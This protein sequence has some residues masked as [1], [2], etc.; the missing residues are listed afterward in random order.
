MAKANVEIKQDEIGFQGGVPIRL[1]R[2]ME[3]KRLLKTHLTQDVDQ[4][5]KWAKR[6]Q[7]GRIEK[8]AVWDKQYRGIKPEKSDPFVG[9]SNVAIPRTRIDVDTVA[10]R[11]FDVIYGQAKMIMV[12]A[13]DE[14]FIPLA[15]Q[16]EDAIEWWQ[17]EVVHL[18]DKLF[19]PMYQALKSG[20]GAVKL[21]FERKKQTQVRYATP[22]EVADENIKTFKVKGNQYATKE[23]RTIFNGPNVYGLAREDLVV[24]SEAVDIDNAKLVGFKFPL[25]EADIKVGVKSGYYYKDVADKMKIPDEVDDTKKA[26]VESQDKE[27]RSHE[28]ED[29]WPYELWLKYDV[30]EDGEPDDIVVIYHEETQTILRA[31]Y[32]PYFS[33]FRPIEK[34]VTYPSEYSFEGVGICERLQGL[35][36]AIDTVFNMRFDRLKQINL[37][38]TIVKSDAG[39]NDF[40]LEPGKTW[41]TD[42]DV[43]AAIR[44]IQF[45]PS[46]PDTERMEIALNN[47]SD[48]SV[49]IGPANLGQPMSERPVA[50]ETFMLIQELNKG[51]KFV[52]DN[53]RD[54]IAKII[55]KALE[56]AAQYSPSWDYYIES[57]GRYEKKTFNFPVE[58]LRDG[59]KVQLTASSEV[60]NQEVRREIG[61]TIWQ[62]LAE[63]MTR[64]AGMAQIIVS[65]GVPADFKMVLLEAN[66]IGV[67]LMKQIIKDFGLI[68]EEKVV[69][70]LAK[71]LDVQKALAMPEQMPPQP[72]QPPQGGGQPQGGQPQGAM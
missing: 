4:K 40:E 50:R 16:L 63:Y 7:E 44:E 41:F 10:V 48:Q 34:L 23:I 58:Y 45:H 57:E 72:G 21:V 1:N 29:F 42:T 2:R 55:M 11:L 69:L 35:Q 9:C 71:T 54:W 14:A 24:S 8:L 39:L 25:S 13:L 53:T 17:K 22:D 31:M 15:P 27:L 61:L 6:N 43:D 52:I 59:I 12:K 19:S 32:N 37:P 3:D 47:Y 20:T 46:Y 66:K 65:P 49:G 51:F 64:V 36:E 28:L 18:K 30:D 26:R 70:D 56:M 33:K 5:L 62:L 68:E 60:M 38:M 67:Y